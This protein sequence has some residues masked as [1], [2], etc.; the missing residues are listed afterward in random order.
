MG[1]YKAEQLVHSGECQARDGVG[2]AVVYAD[3]ACRG[4]SQRRA[5]EDHIGYIA[6]QFVKLFRSHQVPGTAAQHLPGLIQVKQGHAHAVDKAVAAGQHAVIDQQPPFIRLDGGGAGA[7]LGA[8]PA[9]RCAEDIAVAPPIGQVRAAAEIDIAK[10]GMPGIRGAAE[11]HVLTVYFAGKEHAVAV[12]GQKGVFQLVEGDKVLRPAQ[13]DRGAVVT[14]APGDIVLPLD[15]ADARVVAV[16]QL[17]HLRIALEHDWF[18]VDVPV[19]AVVA[20]ARE[21]VHMDSAVVTA[22]HAG[23]AALVGDD[24]GIEHAV[25]AGDGMAF[26]N[27]VVR[28]A[29]DM[30]PGPRGLI[31]PGDVWKRRADDL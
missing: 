11:H 20:E 25:R 10:R 12:V 9:V 27:R 31:L 30:V 19:E 2:A 6:R 7:H 22:E 17:C 1:F 21:Y 18:M 13:A 16:L 26:Y 23:K 5:G 28:I 24:G 3:A 15:E 4:I 8:L 29:P 14:V